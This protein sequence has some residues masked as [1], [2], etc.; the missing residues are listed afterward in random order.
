MEDNNNL[1]MAPGAFQVEESG[2]GPSNPANSPLTLVRTGFNKIAFDSTYNRAFTQLGVEEQDL[3]FFDPNL[4]TIE[5]FFN[6][7]ENLYFLIDDFGVSNSH[8]Y[9]II[10]SSEH[11]DYQANQQEIQ[12]L[13][14]EIAELRETNLQLQIDMAEILGAKATIDNAIRSAN[15]QAPNTIG[16]N[17]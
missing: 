10:Q 14:E 6:I 15:Q 2:L 4:A 11:I 1:N 7:Y 8:E 13:L 9:L 5:D 16:S 3:S 17:G 12:A